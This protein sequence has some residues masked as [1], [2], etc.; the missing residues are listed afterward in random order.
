VASRAELEQRVDELAAELDGAA[1]AEAVRAYS[2]ELDERS[3]EELKAVLLLRARA[4]EDAMDERF[5]AQ[6]WFRR[7][8]G[9]IGDVER[10]HRER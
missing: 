5:E 1:F 10:R 6:G 3:R 4:L 8:L 7:T 2:L 9:R